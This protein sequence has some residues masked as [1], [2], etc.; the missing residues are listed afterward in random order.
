M[1][2]LDKK[3]LE[4]VL[5]EVQKMIDENYKCDN[6]DQDMGYQLALLKVHNHLYSVKFSL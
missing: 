2:K 3:T 5:D 4:Y 1:D 6:V